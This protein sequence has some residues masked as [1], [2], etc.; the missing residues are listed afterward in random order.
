M[1]HEEYAEPSGDTPIWRY[2]NFIKFIA[3]LERGGLYF[4]RADLLGDS[5]EGTFTPCSTQILIER[6]GYT[7]AKAKRWSEI[8]KHIRKNSY[9]TCWHEGEHESAALWRHYGD[10]VAIR[11]T[12]GKLRAFLPD[13]CKIARVRYIDYKNDH[14]DVNY[15]AGPLLFKR[16]AFAHEHEIRALWH[17]FTY[18]GSRLVPN[19]H[20][21]FPG[22]YVEGDLNALIDCM[23]A[24]PQSEQWFI[25]LVHRV[26]KRY[27]LKKICTKSDL[28]ISPPF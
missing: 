3:M 22:E 17:T 9:V 15:S 14:P 28:D 23:V 16:H 20:P 25:E 19:K 21:G 1:E 8:V 26:T 5:F 13:Y 10:A 27:G 12:C 18:E 6:L 2:M 7:K 4:S 11:S 24:A